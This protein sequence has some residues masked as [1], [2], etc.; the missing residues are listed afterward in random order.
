MIVNYLHKITNLIFWQFR[1][2]NFKN[3][4]DND[5]GYALNSLEKNSYFIYK[6]FLNSDEIKKIKTK[7]HLMVL[8][9]R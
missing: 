9:W 2:K 1:K 6:N 3:I 4:A 8:V 5:A 7:P